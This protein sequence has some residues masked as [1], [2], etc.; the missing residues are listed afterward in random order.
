MLLSSDRKQ[1]IARCERVQMKVGELLYQLDE[2]I[3][4]VYARHLG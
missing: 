3:R 4:F 1:M 2:P